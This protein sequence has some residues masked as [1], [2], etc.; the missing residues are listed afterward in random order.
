MLPSGARQRAAITACSALLVVV[1][2]VRPVAACYNVILR[3]I[4][5]PIRE[6]QESARKLERA[7]FKAVAKLVL[8]AFPKMFAVSAGPW[9]RQEFRA[10]GPANLDVEYVKLSY[11]ADGEIR[12]NVAPA[13]A[14][15][16][17]ERMLALAVLRSEGHALPAKVITGFRERNGPQ[18]WAATVLRDGPMAEN[19]RSAPSGRWRAAR[20]EAM[21]WLKGHS[22]A[23]IRELE[24]MAAADT[25]GDPFTWAAL[26]GARKASGKGDPAAAQQM[27]AALAPEAAPCLAYAARVARGLGTLDVRQAAEASR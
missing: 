5:Y 15:Q 21:L 27:C 14:K 13:A 20:L 9:L 6:S 17:A 16:R 26:A 7:D 12:R 2:S 23:A 11:S 22:A 18:R 8:D 4:D 24:A 1:A 25:L 10:G 19:A 3:R